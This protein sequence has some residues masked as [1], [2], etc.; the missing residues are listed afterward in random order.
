MVVF[1]LIPLFAVLVSALGALLIAW[2]GQRRANL[3][4][5]WSIAAGIIQFAI[6]ASMIPDVLAGR[7]PQIVLAR[8]LPGV[9]LG[10]RVD[11]FGLLGAT[12]TVLALRDGVID[13]SGP[14]QSVNRCPPV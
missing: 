11:A 6:V 3:R 14:N 5:S 8:I 12:Y 1:S 10:F 7:S 4:E 2:T 13:R 9:E